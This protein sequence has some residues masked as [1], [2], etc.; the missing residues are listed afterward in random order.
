MINHIKLST[1]DKN[2]GI[3]SK[4]EVNGTKYRIMKDI[5]K[6]KFWFQYVPSGGRVY[7]TARCFG[8][9]QEAKQYIYN[10][11]CP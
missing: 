6:F 8:T 9:F 7:I 11:D 10:A 4:F 5:G 1:N 3:V 2:R